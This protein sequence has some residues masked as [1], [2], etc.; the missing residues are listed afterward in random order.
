MASKKSSSKTVGVEKPRF[1]GQQKKLRLQQVF[2]AI[3]G[4]ILVVAMIA[5]AVI[6]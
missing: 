2:M 1:S 6:R 3:F 4:I 5:A